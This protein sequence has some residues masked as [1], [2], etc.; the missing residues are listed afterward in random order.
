MALGCRLEKGVQNV[1]IVKMARTGTRNSLQDPGPLREKNG[2]GPRGEKMD[3]SWAPLPS[4]PRPADA[5][6]AAE[7]L[8]ALRSRVVSRSAA[9]PTTLHG[10]GDEQ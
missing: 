10:G 4:R 7:R 5:P 6:T 3:D 9:P 2:T 8:A 1:R